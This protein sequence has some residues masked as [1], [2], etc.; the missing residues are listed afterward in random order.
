MNRRTGL[1][2]TIGF[3]ILIIL[4]ILIVDAPIISV[5][6]IIFLGVGILISLIIFVF[7]PFNYY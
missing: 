7:F 3:A 5:P 1:L 4:A 2:I 6:S